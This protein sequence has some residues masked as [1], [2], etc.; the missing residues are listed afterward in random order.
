EERFEIATPVGD[1]WMWG[2][3]TGKPIAL[4][5]TGAFAD[6]H[7]YS[8]LQLV[9]PQFDVLRT[10]LP[11]NHCPELIDISVGVMASG[12]SQALTSHF[13]GRPMVAIGLSTGALVAMALTSPDLKALLLVEPFL[14]TLQIWPFR[15]MVAEYP[16][17]G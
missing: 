5:M 3:D 14:R 10:H 4:V 15:G 17:A 8:R 2:R 7:I 9:L 16:S 12:V 13:G 6:A 11:G 1:I